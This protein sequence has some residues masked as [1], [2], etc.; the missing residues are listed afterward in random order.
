[1]DSEVTNKSRLRTSHLLIQKF[2]S[3]FIDAPEGD[4]LFSTWYM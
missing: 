1:M 4:L 3:A 2:P